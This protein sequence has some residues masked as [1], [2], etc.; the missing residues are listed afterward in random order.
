MSK[1]TDDVKAETQ[2]ITEC[3]ETKFQNIVQ[4]ACTHCGKEFST[5]TKMRRH[6]KIHFDTN[7]VNKCNICHK[8][9]K[10]SKSIIKHKGEKVEEKSVGYI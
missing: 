3:P 1:S 7:T 2:I 6:E 8:S 10:Y 5:E 9:F 4:H